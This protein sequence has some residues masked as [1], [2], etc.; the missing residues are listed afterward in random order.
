MTS[1]K[2]GVLHYRLTILIH[3]FY[4]NIMFYLSVELTQM[5][6]IVQEIPEPFPLPTEPSIVKAAAGWAHCVAATGKLD[7]LIAFP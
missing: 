7:F 2:H 1:G 3:E 4:V 5:L 6:V